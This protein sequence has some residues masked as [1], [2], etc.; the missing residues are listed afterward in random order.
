ME[1]HHMN[2]Q[3]LSELKGDLF[4]ARVTLHCGDLTDEERTAALYIK[5][6]LEHRINNIENGIIFA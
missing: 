6:G 2:T 5:E 1:K 3:L 4:A